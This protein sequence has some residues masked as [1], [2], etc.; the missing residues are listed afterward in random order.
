MK[1]FEISFFDFAI[2]EI[3][4][5]ANLDFCV[6]RRSALPSPWVETELASKK[7]LCNLC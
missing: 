6:L 5:F 2:F 3:S 4:I 7:S 1:V